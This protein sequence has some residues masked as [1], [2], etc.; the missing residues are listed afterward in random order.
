MMKRLIK[1]LAFS[2]ACLF[3]FIGLLIGSHYIGQ[4]MA[5]LDATYGD[6][7]VLGAFTGTFLLITFTAGW[8]II[9]D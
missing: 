1:S 6:L 3:L 2:I 4:F 5:F 7:A 9:E 8:F